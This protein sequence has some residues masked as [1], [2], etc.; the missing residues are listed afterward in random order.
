[1][2]PLD[3][4]TQDDSETASWP[5][6]G[7][8]SC[9]DT[10]K[11]NASA[12]RDLETADLERLERQL[13]KQGAADAEE[14]VSQATRSYPPH[15]E[16]QARHGDDDDS[17]PPSLP[18]F[19]IVRELG[20]GGMGR[21]YLA[22]DRKLDRLVALKTLRD[23]H[24]SARQLQR[25]THEIQA[26]SRLNHPSIVTIHD[27]SLQGDLPFFTMEY[28]DGPSGRELFERFKNADARHGSLKEILS[29]AGVTGDAALSGLHHVAGRSGTYFRLI[30]WWVAQVA[31]ALQR[32]H[33]AGIWHRDIKPGN[34]LLS[35][36]GRMKIADFG[37]A[38]SSDNPDVT[39]AGL[40]LG[41]SRYLSPERLTGGR[42]YDHRSDIYALGLTLYELLTF[43]HARCGDSNEQILAEIMSKD[44]AR[45][46]QLVAEVPAELERICLKTIVRDPQAR[47]AS[48]GELAG[49]LLAWLGQSAA[50]PGA[51][52]L[53]SRPAVAAVL[54]ALLGAGCAA[55][56]MRNHGNANAP[57][58]ADMMTRASDQATP[59]LENGRAQASMAGAIL[60]VVSNQPA[61][62]PAEVAA[63]PAPATH[64]G[65]P[66]VMLAFVE[67][68]DA[69]DGVPAF[70]DGQACSKFREV[71]G[72]SGSARIMP[73]QVVGMQTWTPADAVK[74]GRQS[75]AD[76]VIV[77]ESLMIP[78]REIAAGP[79]N[80][81]DVDQQVEFGERSVQDRIR[82]RSSQRNT[83][84]EWQADLKI[85]LIR[86]VDGAVVDSWS[87]T[88][89][90]N[91]IQVRGAGPVR[92]MVRKTAGEAA[93]K[94]L[95]RLADPRL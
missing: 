13:Q 28:V 93:A 58:R 85:S 82:V 81:F 23:A 21:V 95:S 26:A 73:P 70:A 92:D 18:G 78:V 47:Y 51:L 59:L 12:S 30:A 2:D 89:D 79:T 42:T 76:Y 49:E 80:G 14:T 22:R 71:L 74:V 61:S 62:A 87:V 86:M 15:P 91:A 63:D 20:R 60:P 52:T 10:S 37:L 24:W 50:R 77:G 5:M 94:V 66:R 54:I 68:D 29:I 75:G 84:Y 19:E 31:E 34:L 64:T 53:R 8:P 43:H 83:T 90:R 25:F 38:R 33:E 48:A 39:Q 16:A 27:C 88:S 11:S 65:P 72:A 40:L 9:E 17:T 55:G 35:P 4:R 6:M 67:D 36:D 7:V 57:A 3:N 32:L 44:P 69:S 1:M 41:S 46:R 45:P 56:L